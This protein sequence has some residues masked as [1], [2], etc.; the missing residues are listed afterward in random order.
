MLKC[1]ECGN[2]ASFVREGTIR[3]VFDDKGFFLKWDDTSFEA[4]R[5]AAGFTCPECDA[6]VRS[7]CELWINL[8]S[9]KLHA[10]PHYRAVVADLEDGRRIAFWPP[11]DVLPEDLVSCPIIPAGW[12]LDAALAKHA[13]EPLETVQIPAWVLAKTYTGSVS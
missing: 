11:S 1:T 10:T 5:W 12:S 8:D 2:T 3:G 9:V 4:P 13:L 7:V 6:P